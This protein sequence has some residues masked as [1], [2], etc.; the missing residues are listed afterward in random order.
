VGLGHATEQS[1]AVA[2]QCTGEQVDRF[3]RGRHCL[4]PAQL[5]AIQPA[6]RFC[7]QSRTFCCCSACKLS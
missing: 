5:R 6:R 3:Q 2:A 7:I 4:L 1:T